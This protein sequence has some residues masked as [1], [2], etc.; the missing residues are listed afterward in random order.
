M[1]CKIQNTKRSKQ[2]MGQLPQERQS[3][4]EPIFSSTGIG[5]FGPIQ[6]NSLVSGV[7]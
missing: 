5:Y 3:V 1:P 7:H 6:N 2:L 4:F